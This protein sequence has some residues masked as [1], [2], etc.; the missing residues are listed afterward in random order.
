[1]PF[2]SSIGLTLGPT[3]RG[4]FARPLHGICE[5]VPPMFHGD[6]IFA[7]FPYLLLNLICASMLMITV[8]VV[9]VF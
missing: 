5:A 1:M 4:P 2:F 8:I 9:L 6:S 7:M 3:I